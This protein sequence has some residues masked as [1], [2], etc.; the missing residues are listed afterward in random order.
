MK[1][2]RPTCSVPIEYRR[3]GT[4]IA[5][6]DV[7]DYLQEVYEKVNPATWEQWKHEQKDFGGTKPGL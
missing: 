5:D 3:T 2:Y 1:I 6:N 4:E 7:D